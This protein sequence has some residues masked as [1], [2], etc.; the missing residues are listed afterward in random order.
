MIFLKIARF[1]VF[2]LALLTTVF[3]LSTFIS[4]IVTPNMKYD[5]KTGEVKAYARESRLWAVLIAA[6]LWAIL[7]AFL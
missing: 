5:E 4:D 1:V 6:V 3:W 7:F 2:L